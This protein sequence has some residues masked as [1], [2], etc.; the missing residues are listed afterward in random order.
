MAN[1]RK[2]QELFPDEKVRPSPFG[3]TGVVVGNAPTV[4]RCEELW[5]GVQAALDVGCGV[6]V[7]NTRDGG[8]LCI[9][10]FDGG[11]RHKTY[12]TDAEQVRRAG[13]AMRDLY[14]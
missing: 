10:V 11:D 9:T 5:D 6:M 7:G 2:P 13:L 8:A 14:K 3:N 1:K 4:N 12:M